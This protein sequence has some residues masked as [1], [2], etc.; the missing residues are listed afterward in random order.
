MPARGHL[1]CAQTAG[2][3]PSSSTLFSSFLPGRCCPIAVRLTLDFLRDALAA[4][5]DILRPAGPR[6]EKLTWEDTAREIALSTG[7][8][9]EWDHVAC[10]GLENH[11]WDTTVPS[12]AAERDARYKTG[13]APAVT[14][15]HEIRWADLEPAQGAEMAKRRPVVI[16]KSCDRLH[17]SRNRLQCVAPLILLQG[18]RRLSPGLGSH[19][20]FPG[21]SEASAR[22][23]SS[24]PCDASRT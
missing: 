17:N 20:G 21:L 3:R 19:P 1:V 12:K 22:E 16:V 2:L 6:V 7:D 14:K 24:M 5:P 4:V 23:S 8:W 13:R 18:L 11:P 15:R 9:R 10:D